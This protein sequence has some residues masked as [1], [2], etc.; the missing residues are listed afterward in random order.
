MPL[1]RRQKLIMAVGGALFGNNA[2]A[3][4]SKVKLSYSFGD[5]FLTESPK[6][7][8]YRKASE[9]MLGVSVNIES[10]NLGS[11]ISIL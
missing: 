2:A 8:K 6:R 3:R 9:V 7:S 5:F 1:S 11:S 4:Q 10:P